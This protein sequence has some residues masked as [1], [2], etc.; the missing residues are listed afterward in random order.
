VSAAFMPLE[1]EGGALREDFHRLVNAREDPATLAAAKAGLLQALAAVSPEPAPAQRSSP[2]ASVDETAQPEPQPAWL[3]FHAPLALLEGAWLQT[4]AQPI[5]GHEPVVAEL[6]AAYLAL[7]GN[8]EAASPA[9]AYRGELN[10][11][12]IALSPVESWN[13]AHDP[14]I[15]EAALHF[16]SL[17]LCLGCH[18]AEF[19]PEALG[20]TL[21]YLRSVSPWRLPTLSPALRSARLETIARHAEAAMQLFLDGGGDAVRVQRGHALYQ[22][23]EAAYLSEW[24]RVCQQPAGLS[25]QVGA[26]F[27]RK[28]RFAQGYHAK[29]R[30]AGRCLEDWFSATPFDAAGFLAA[31]AASPYAQGQP[32]QRLFERLAAFGG[33]MFGVFEQEELALLDAWLATQQSYSELPAV[34]VS[35]ARLLKPPSHQDKTAPIADDSR[36]LFHR[37]INQ[38]PDPA[39]HAAARRRVERILARSRRA[40]PF[41]R[42][43]RKRFFDYQPAVFAERIA[44]FHHAETAKYQGFQAPPKLRREEYVWGLRQFA[45]AVLVDGSWLRHQTAAAWQDQRIR[46]LLQRIYA[47]EL[48]AGKTE[49]NHPRL[50]RE[51]LEELGINLPATDTEAFAR[52]PGFLDAAFDLPV[53]LLAISLCPTSYLPETLGL[54]LAIELSGLGAGYLRLADEM[55]YWQINPLIVKLHLS[56]DNLAAG[57]SAMACKAIQLY[58]EETRAL[59]GEAAMQQAW[60]RIWSGYLSLDMA[61]KRFKWALI[62]AFCR[63]FLPGRLLAKRPAADRHQPV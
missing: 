22:A 40:M 50:Y 54:N 2:A 9:H 11:H 14:R 7:L 57:H 48:G 59:A 24:Q 55:Q 21:A 1:G 46:R 6:F 12:G 32:G 60:L 51:L 8:D 3:A 20:F 23:A 5:N 34:P 38:D 35:P 47:E 17:Q 15:G 4:L 45:P 13:F 49:W 19:L 31:F 37:L 58:L 30:L 43:L 63:E 28:R 10:R 29:V 18:A 26:M 16:A 39:L 56:I 25:A 27:Q 53:Y 62:M 33:P 44:Q 41:Q 36:L 42:A 52:H 61:A